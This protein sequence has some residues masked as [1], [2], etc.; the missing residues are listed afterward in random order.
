MNEKSF[1]NVRINWYPGH[2][3]K[4][5]K[6]IIEDLKLVDVVIELLDARIPKSSQNP[7]IGELV[8]NKKRIVILN[9][10]DLADEKETK[11][12]IDY[13]KNKNIKALEIDSN[14]GNGIQ[15]VTK[16][17][18]GLMEEELKLQRLK[19]SIDIE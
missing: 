15:N 11:K 6:Q 4:T 16:A 19:D 5:K 14:Q 18:E 13:F 7:D 1:S 12:W 10:S 9:K 2:M 3:A 8:K 17:I